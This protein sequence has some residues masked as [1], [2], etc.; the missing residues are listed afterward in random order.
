M[1]D[2]Y[3]ETNRYTKEKPSREKAAHSVYASM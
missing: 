1:F 2:I 3:T